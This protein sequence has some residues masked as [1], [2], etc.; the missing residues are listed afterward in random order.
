M[1]KLGLLYLRGGQWQGK[2]VVPRSWVEESTRMQVKFGRSNGHT[3]GYGYL[4]WILGP[5]P[6]GAGRERIYAAMG[7]RA[8]YI[9]VVPEHDLVVVLTGGTRS[10]A[11]EQ[12]PIGFLYS[13]ILSAVRR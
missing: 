12:R 6:D 1:A 7:F 10:Y 4:W 8:Q 9:F 5:D 2:E 13:D 11:D 3:I